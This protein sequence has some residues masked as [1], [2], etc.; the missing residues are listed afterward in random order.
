VAHTARAVWDAINGPNL[1]AHIRPTR[2]QAS[3]VVVKG[4]DHSIVRVELA[5][6]R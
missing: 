3:I 5:N 4:A 6:G 2:S 1:E